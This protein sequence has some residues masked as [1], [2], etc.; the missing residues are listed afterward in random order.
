MLKEDEP[1]GAV[2]SVDTATISELIRRGS[3]A[4]GDD[5]EAA[6]AGCKEASS[7]VS[8]AF[9]AVSISATTGS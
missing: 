4:G 7:L 2:G 5:I 9:A 3:S 8:P 6:E 1:L